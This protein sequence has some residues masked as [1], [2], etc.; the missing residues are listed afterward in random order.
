MGAR[1][2]RK[3]CP[4]IYLCGILNLTR[5]EV[6]LLARRNIIAVDLSYFAAD[7]DEYDHSMRHRTALD[8]F[9]KKLELAKPLDRRAWALSF[10]PPKEEIPEESFLRLI[11]SRRLSV[12]YCQN[13]I[14]Y[15]KSQR[16][17]YPGWVTCPTD[18]LRALVGVVIWLLRR[19]LPAILEILKPVQKLIFLREVSWMLEKALLPIT[20]IET[21]VVNIVNVFNPTLKEFDHTVDISRTDENY[22]NL[23]WLEIRECW[24]ELV[25]A[26]ARRASEKLDQT[27]HMKWMNILKDIVTGNE[28][29]KL[30]YWLEECRYHLYTL[31]IKKLKDFLETDT[32][33][34]TSPRV[35]LKRGLRY[36][37]SSGCWMKRKNLY[38]EHGKKCVTG[39]PLRKTIT[40]RYQ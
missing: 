39:H 9:L 22:G 15:F 3:V 6:E 2:P 36:F 5:P 27:E 19:N 7:V 38:K 17:Q 37:C 34:I 13:L 23:D 29:W 16:E 33:D 24:V 8:G 20:I 25:V 40:R 31:N 10:D 18:N 4:P 26:L 21:H 14:G 32:I 30:R 12:E 1:Q 11:G 35:A 28:D